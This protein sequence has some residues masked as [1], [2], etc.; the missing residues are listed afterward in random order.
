MRYALWRG[1]IQQKLN[2]IQGEWYRFAGWV[3]VYCSTRD[4]NVSQGG[5]FH[6]RV[7]V[8]PWGNWPHYYDPV[9]GKEAEKP[10]DHWAQVE[11]IAQAWKNEMTVFAEGL[12]EHTVNH[13]DVYWDNFTFEHISAPDSE[14]EP[15]DPEPPTGECDLTQVLDNQA[16]IM[17]AL[18]NVPK[19][20]ESLKWV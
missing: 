5:T 13:N 15:P 14:P 12:A 11:V 16:E 19:R 20:D 18:A 8:N 3:W 7:G 4:D 1:G 9:C 10:Y 2:V 17:L 6:A